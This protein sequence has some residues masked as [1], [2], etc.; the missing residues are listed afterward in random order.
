VGLWS[1]FTCIWNSAVVHHD[2]DSQSSPRLW[3]V[4]FDPLLWPFQN[5]CSLSAR[6]AE[7]L[8]A[9]SIMMPCQVKQW[10]SNCQIC[11]LWKPYFRTSLRKTVLTFMFIN[12]SFVESYAL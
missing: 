8:A 6:W 1:C 2:F 4:P 12:I 10:C 9:S 7:L 11:D 5:T 3:P